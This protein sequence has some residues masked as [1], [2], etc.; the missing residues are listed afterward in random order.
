MMGKIHRFLGMTLIVLALVNGGL[1]FDFAENSNVAYAVVVAAM[2]VVY[3]ALTVLVWRY[4][5]KHVYRPE[6]EAMAQQYASTQP[7]EYEM[8]D[9][10]FT[11]HV[12]TPQTPHFFAASKQYQGEN[13]RSDPE[14]YRAS[15][16]R[17]N[18]VDSMRQES[19]YT[20][21]PASD[22]ENPFKGKW[23]AVPMR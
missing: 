15:L 11:D 12:Q 16:V 13:Y 2:A 19:L 18:T 10:P 23:E 7:A 21:T 5:R 17:S 3:A 14:G 9:A 1:G 4:N 22:H 6:K 8:H 20:D